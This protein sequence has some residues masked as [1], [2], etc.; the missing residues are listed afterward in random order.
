MCALVF[1][2]ADGSKF[3]V[4]FTPREYGGKPLV[5]RLVVQTDEMQWTYEVRG[6]HPKWVPPQTSNMPVSIDNRLPNVAQDR[7]R[8][9]SLLSSL[10]PP[11]HSLAVAAMQ[12]IGRS[13]ARGGKSAGAG[14]ASGKLPEIRTPSRS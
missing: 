1:V 2:R 9:P 6:S 8:L 4:S 10:V 5:G 13:G 12:S 7:V 14:S 3:V 11:A